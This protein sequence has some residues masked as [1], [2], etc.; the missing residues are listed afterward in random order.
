MSQSPLELYQYA[1]HLHYEENNFS[2]AS[3]LYQQI[4]LAFPDS[5]ESGYAA[6]QLQKI[7]SKSV[8][9]IFEAKITKRTLLLSSAFSFLFICVIALFIWC[10]TTNNA[11]KSLQQRQTDLATINSYFSLQAYQQ[12]QSYIANLGHA[13]ANDTLM[14]MYA[15]LASFFQQD[16]T[17]LRE[18]LD[19]L[20]ENGHS[21]FVNALLVQLQSPAPKTTYTR[22]REK[23][24]TAKKA[25]QPPE[26]PES[27]EAL[28]DLREKILS[29]YAQ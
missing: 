16:T 25:L 6:I 13:P 18:H 10:L 20:K 1:Y 11:V 24:T 17:Q 3:E 26:K 4:I 22:V 2:K 9:D 5:H 14:H 7:H 21:T 15:A 8:A 29:N 28:E 23:S 12:A 19:F 27:N